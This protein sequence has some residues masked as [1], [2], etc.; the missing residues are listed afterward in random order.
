VMPKPVVLLELAARDTDEI[1][2]AYVRTNAQRAAQ[3]FSN[4]VKQACEHIGRYPDSG[5]LRLAEGLDIPDLRS[6]RLRKF[7][8]LVF[9]FIRSDRVE[10]CRVIHGRR[11]VRIDA[12]FIEMRRQLGLS[13]SS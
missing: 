8:H 7:P 10:V 6:W 13:N 2:E 5:S 1:I 4:A 9:Y 11:A 12:G 3:G